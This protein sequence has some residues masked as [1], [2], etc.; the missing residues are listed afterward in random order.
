MRLFAPPDYTWLGLFCV[1]IGELG[2]LGG[3]LHLG[4]RVFLPFLWPSGMRLHHSHSATW[5]GARTASLVRFPNPSMLCPIVAGHTDSLVV[6]LSASGY[7]AGFPTCGSSRTACS[8][9][10]P[11]QPQTKPGI[12]MHG[13]PQS[14]F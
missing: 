13:M 11:W 10:L 12:G 5:R 7:S 3:I 8:T 1:I 14:A 6:L 4:R 2:S 9:A